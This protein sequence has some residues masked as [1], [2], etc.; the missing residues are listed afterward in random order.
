MSPRDAFKLCNY[1]PECGTK[2]EVFETGRGLIKQCKNHPYSLYLAGGHDGFDVMAYD[3]N[4][5]IRLQKK[6]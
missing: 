1:C 3:P 6:G 4:R 5:A 2:L